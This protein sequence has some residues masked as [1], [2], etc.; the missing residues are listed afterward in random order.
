MAKARLLT[1][2]GQGTSLRRQDYTE[3]AIRAVKDALWHNSINL[4]ELFGRERTDMIIDVEIG[5]G[6]P[7][8]VDIEKVKEVFPYGQL[9]VTAREGGLDVP[10]TDGNPPNVIVVVA[11]SVSFD[12]EDAA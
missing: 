10:R 4:A 5:A 3:A 11:I 6:Q 1:E 8:Q 7:D 9:S 12:L 2:F